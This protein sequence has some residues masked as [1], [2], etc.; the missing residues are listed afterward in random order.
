[1]HSLCIGSILLGKK[2]YYPITATTYLKCSF[3]LLRTQRSRVCLLSS[4]C[5]II[6]CYALNKISMR[7]ASKS[8][9]VRRSTMEHMVQLLALIVCF[10]GFL[11][12]YH[13]F[14]LEATFTLAYNALVY[15][16]AKKHITAILKSSQ[17]DC[18]VSGTRFNSR[19]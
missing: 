12:I 9:L 19:N 4:I 8:S 18:L 16:M 7:L 14:Q 5:P 1:V 2:P 11:S 13:Y 17:L 10:I 15:C 3:K 6:L